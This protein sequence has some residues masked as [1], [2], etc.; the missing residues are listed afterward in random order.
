MIDITK[1]YKTRDGRDVIILTTI[2]KGLHPV[3]GLVMHSNGVESLESWDLYGRW[4]N[5]D[6]PADL[7][8]V[9]EKK[10]IKVFINIYSTYWTSGSWYTT[11]EQ[12][13]N[14]KGVDRKACKEIEIEYEEGEGL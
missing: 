10:K 5:R 4:G 7:I 1:K 11:K 13:D 14:R 12:A 9:K 3:I 2:R 8:E 6:T